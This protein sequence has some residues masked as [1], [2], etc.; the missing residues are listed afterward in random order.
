MTCRA[1]QILPANCFHNV[2]GVSLELTSKKQRLVHVFSFVHKVCF[3]NQ[4]FA[5]EIQQS[6]HNPIEP[7]AMPLLLVRIT[8]L[9]TETP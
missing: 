3:Q 7:Q 2:I 9:F 8:R 5:K 1:C 4:E 6:Q